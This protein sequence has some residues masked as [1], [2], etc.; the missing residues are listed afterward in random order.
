MKKYIITTLLSGIFVTASAYL[1]LKIFGLMVALLS[2][3]P[4]TLLPMPFVF[5]AIDDIEGE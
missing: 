4:L 2:I 3:I 5:K 1:M